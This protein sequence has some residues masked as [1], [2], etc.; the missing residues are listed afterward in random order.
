MRRGLRAA[1]EQ[2]AEA[3]VLSEVGVMVDR[4]GIADGLR[5]SPGVARIKRHHR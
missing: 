5:K 1:G 3:R 4:I 2:T